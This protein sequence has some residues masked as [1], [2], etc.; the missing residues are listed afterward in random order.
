MTWWKLMHCK[1]KSK[2][3]S[4]SKAANIYCCFNFVRNETYERV[5]PSRC[6]SRNIKTYL[7]FNLL[8]LSKIF[9]R[10]H[11]RRNLV[12]FCH[13]LKNK[14]K[15]FWVGYMT[16]GISDFQLKFSN[17]NPPRKLTSKEL[18]LLCHAIWICVERFLCLP[19]VFSLTS[20]SSTFMNIKMFHSW[21]RKRQRNIAWAEG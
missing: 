4:D 2:Y 6:H 3:L 16:T 1:R 12:F 5:K 19:I 8:N 21:G 11:S 14:I 7:M 18:S 15:T 10:L 17:A 9:W 20:W 13:H